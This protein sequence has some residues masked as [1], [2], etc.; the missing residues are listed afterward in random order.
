M[1]ARIS[2]RQVPLSARVYARS[3]TSSVREGSVASS[4]EFGKKEQAHENQYIKQEERKKLEK[5]R[6][7]MEKK[8]AELAELQ[9]EHDEISST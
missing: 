8:K 4:K 6:A 9:K 1:L 5:L 3:Y 7:Q 2:F